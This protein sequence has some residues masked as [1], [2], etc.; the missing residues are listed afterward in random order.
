MGKAVTAIVFAALNSLLLFSAVSFLVTGAQAA[1]A[2]SMDFLSVPFVGPFLLIVAV[3]EVFLAWAMALLFS[4]AVP[5]L[6]LPY[7][8]IF[9]AY[10]V[11][12]NGLVRRRYSLLF[13]GAFAVVATVTTIVLATA[14][15]KASQQ[16]LVLL[17]FSGGTAALSG[18][19]TSFVLLVLPKDVDRMSRW[20]ARCIPHGPGSA[21]FWIALLVIFPF[22][23][24]L[25]SIDV[26]QLIA[27]CSSYESCAKSPKIESYRNLLPLPWMLVAL[28]CWG[29]A[30]VWTARAVRRRR[31]QREITPHGH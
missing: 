18:Y 1:G 30:A 11:V 13:S 12:P 17:L 14:D 24:V 31:M 10:L 3:G 2:V 9:F 7:R 6:A 19:L 28:V 21:V 23:F 20:R 8:I 22:V 5:V 15:T 16:W 29:I 27:G 4:L 26:F 25:G